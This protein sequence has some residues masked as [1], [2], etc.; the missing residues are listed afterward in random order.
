MEVGGQVGPGAQIIR[1]LKPTYSLFSL[2]LKCQRLIDHFQISILYFS[3]GLPKVILYCVQECLIFLQIFG[4][5]ITDID[6]FTNDLIDMKFE[7]PLII[8]SEKGV[9]R[10]KVMWGAELSGWYSLESSY[11]L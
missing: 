8:E 2:S 9:D 7:Q 5:A 3:F 6:I 10:N 1:V 11:R 4:R